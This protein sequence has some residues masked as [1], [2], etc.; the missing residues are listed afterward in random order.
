[1]NYALRVERGDQ[2]KVKEK[3]LSLGFELLESKDCL[4]H[5]RSRSAVVKMYPSGSIL[6]QGKDAFKVKE[7]VL[8]TLEVPDFVSVGCDE[9]GKGDVF[10]PLVLCCAVIKPEYYRKVLELN[11]KDCKKMEDNQVLEKAKAFK[12]F[13]DFACKLVEPFVLNSIY[14]DTPN[15]NRV[16]DGLYGEL[17]KALKERYPSAKFFVDAYSSRNPFLNE[18]VFETKGE[19]ILSVAVASVLARA[20]FL[21]WLTERR[22][23]KGSSGD[24]MSLAKRL[25]EKNPQQAKKLLKVFFL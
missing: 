2:Q 19:R 14:E 13:G 20:E 22:L 3:L 5:L 9:S 15:L 24:S 18:V 8:S 10:G 12:S 7:L 25:Y 23:P 1:M 21:S 4:W 16:M 11:I 17:L 6:I